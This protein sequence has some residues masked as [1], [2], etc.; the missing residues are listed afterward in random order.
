MA[1]PAGSL[2]RLR[3]RTADEL[4][5]G[6]VLVVGGGQSGVQ[7]AEDLLHAG[8]RVF[9]ATST[10]GRLPRRYR[11]SLL[12]RANSRLRSAARA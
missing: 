3:Y 10:V 1:C 12:E 5:A 4:P 9:L 6:S 7:I 11:D 2:P 8:R